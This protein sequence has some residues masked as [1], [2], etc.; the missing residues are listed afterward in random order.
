MNRTDATVKIRVLILCTGNSAR[1]QM[2]EGLL[3][4]MSGGVVDVASAGTEPSRVHP[5]AIRVMGERGIDISSH[6]S[7]HLNTLVESPFDH[8]ITV[9]DSAGDNCPIFP[10]SALRT[11]WSLPDPASV[12]GEADR[13]EA[14]REVAGLLE[15]HLKRFLSDLRSES[16]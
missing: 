14:F 15:G 13:L 16:S 7:K 6:T 3:R 5:L 4:A 1:S 8:V 10:G 12:G 11:H 9:C 2:G